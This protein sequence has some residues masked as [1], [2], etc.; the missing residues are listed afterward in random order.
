VSNVAGPAFR[1]VPR[2]DVAGAG[3]RTYAPAVRSPFVGVLVLACVAIVAT[4]AGASEPSAR[5]FEATARVTEFAAGEYGRELAFASTCGAPRLWI[6][7]TPRPTALDVIRPC[8]RGG[9][10]YALSHAGRV[11]GWGRRDAG[12]FSFWLALASLDTGSFHRRAR[13]IAI[14]APDQ[15]GGALLVG[16]GRGNA[17]PYAVGRTVYLASQDTETGEPFKERIAELPSRPLWLSRTAGVIAVRRADGPVVILEESFRALLR[18]YDYRPDVV[19]AA[20]LYGRRVVV[21]RDGRLDWHDYVPARTRT[22]RLPPARS[23]GDGFCGRPP[24]TRAELRL[25]D[26]HRDLVVYVLRRQIH[27]LRLTD[28]KDVVVRTPDKGPVEAQI[29]GSGLSYSAGRAISFVPM[30]RVT[31]L[32]NER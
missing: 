14:S 27:V 9:A 3:T 22:L 23:Y 31:Q 13:R 16:E 11:L 29:E 2:A 32:L 26:L 17:V 8:S 12:G 1:N 6:V 15:S 5:S 28:G 24:C 4:A 30:R 21:L 19:R 10:P 18:T 7:G 25:E 20:K